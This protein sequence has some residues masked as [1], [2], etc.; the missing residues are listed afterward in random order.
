[1]K[2]IKVPAGYVPLYVQS[3]FVEIK[4]ATA[5]PR[6]QKREE[7]FRKF[8]EDACR[9]VFESINWY[10]ETQNV[11]WLDVLAQALEHFHTTKQAYRQILYK[12]E[13]LKREE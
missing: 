5:I 7:K 8:F 3:E 11:E 6:K 10:C 4:P 12:N 1:M 2:R 9:F 13:G